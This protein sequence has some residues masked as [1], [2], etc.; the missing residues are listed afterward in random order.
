[1]EAAT[2]LHR[3]RVRTVAGHVQIDGLVIADEATV[4][5]VRAREDAREDPTS[6]LVDAIEIGAR[7]LDREQAAAQTEFVRAEFERVSRD[8]ETS[9]AERAEAVSVK[10]TT[11]FDS[12]FSPESGHL[13]KALERHF[14]DDSSAAVQHR[15]KAVMDDVMRKSREDLLRQFTTADGQ[16]PLAEFK[17]AS[18][19]AIRQMSDQQ[20]E[21]LRAMEARLATLQAE[22]AKLQTEKDKQVEIDEERERGTAKGRTYEEAVFEAVDRIANAQGDVAEAVGDLTGTTGRVGDVV[23]E[24]DGCSGPPRGRVV[25]EA[26]N[27]QLSRPAALRELDQALVDRDAQFAILVV[28]SEE[29]VPPRMA[30]LREYNGDKLIVSFEPDDE[31]GSPLGLEL[32]LKLARARVLMARGEEGALD[33]GALRETI[34]RALQAM[35]QV[36]AVKQQL[37][38][39]T[40]SIEKAR[41]IVD[42][43]A[44]RVRELLAE[45]DA[46]LAAAQSS[47][48]EE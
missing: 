2:P 42:D 31:D 7:V 18:V 46:K 13:S 38:H 1:M 48:D 28:P 41:T 45:I 12:V 30:Q 4:S 35:E 37:T 10:L 43:L 9:F 15:V 26:K 14:S 39:A 34:E 20:S 5:L 8:V 3:P 19:R 29:K 16:N 47:R 21:G 32:G 36:R 6:A 11:Q 27:R 40:G 23:V 24:L 17:A 33:A 22:I 44:G 25:I